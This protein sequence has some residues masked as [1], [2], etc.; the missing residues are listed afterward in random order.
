MKLYIKDSAILMKKSFLKITLFEIICF[1]ISAAVIFPLYSGL[2]KLS[3]LFSGINYLSSYNLK[4][5]LKNPG[6]NFCLLLAIVIFALWI[7]FNCAA[8]VKCYADAINNKEIKI[9]EMFYAG[10]EALK[11]AFKKKQFGIIL[12]ALSI[13]PFLQAG[14]FLSIAG[15]FG[16]PEHFYRHKLFLGSVIA[17]LAAFSIAAFRLWIFVP[18]NVFI[19]KFSYRSSVRYSR[20]LTKYSS[21]RFCFGI[22]L[23]VALVSSVF[24]ASSLLLSAVPGHAIQKFAH[25]G[26]IW[27]KNAFII[28]RI[29]FK[30]VMLL[31]AVYSVPVIFSYTTVAFFGRLKELCVENEY[32]DDIK[33]VPV[34]SNAKKLAAMLT[35]LAVAVSIDG[36]IILSGAISGKI[37]LGF[38]SVPKISAHRG[39]SYKAPENTVPAFEKAINIGADYIELDIQETSDSKIVVMHDK[40]LKRTTGLDKNIWEV[41]YNT[42]SHLDAGSWFDEKYKGTV[43]PTLEYVLSMTKGKI[44]LNIEIKPAKHQKNIVQ[45]TARL[46]KKYHFEKDCYVTSFSYKILKKIKKEDPKIKTAYTMSVAYGNVNVLKYADAVSVNKAF[47]TRRFVG[48]CHG[49]GKKV[50]AWTVDKKKDIQKMSDIS[51]DNIITN[52]PEKAI[53]EQGK[54][55]TGKSLI[56]VYKYFAQ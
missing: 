44:K 34:K 40:N 15:A 22:I 12:F 21:L 32:F 52:K 20:A 3:F 55:Y 56:A 45:E 2:L 47:I 14:M 9:H 36:T 35:A 50:F 26:S 6:T 18:Q 11:T 31:T 41:D 38:Y 29:N 43:I 28:L 8:C 7:W 54:V 25:M 13:L 27:A 49:S 33:K 24:L 1:T 51:V 19:N 23:W 17:V 46:I 10:L 5:F 30:I 39:Y 4:R 48:Q 16:I 53:S 42:V 37:N